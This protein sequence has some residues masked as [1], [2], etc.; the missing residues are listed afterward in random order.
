M[1]VLLYGC[2]SFRI[3]MEI[4]AVEPPR[5]PPQPTA[6]FFEERGIICAMHWLL[7]RMKGS[8]CSGFSWI[9]SIMVNGFSKCQSSCFIDLA[10]Q[11][12]E[13]TH[14]DGILPVLPR[15]LSALPVHTE[16]GRKCGFHSLSPLWYI[17]HFYI[18]SLTDHS[19][20]RL[21]ASQLPSVSLFTCEAALADSLSYFGLPPLS[22]P[23]LRRQLCPRVKTHTLVLRSMF[24]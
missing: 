7:L 8:D 16:P 20:R 12:G 9:V 17:M 23:P 14:L 24:R 6:T 22:F 13:Q 1:S 18:Q 5:H 11:R 10:S 3:D 4:A 21:D 19:H 2:H 15:Q